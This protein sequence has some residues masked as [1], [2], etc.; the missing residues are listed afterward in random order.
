MYPLLEVRLG[1]IRGNV[2][3]IMRMCRDSGIEP[4]AVIKGFNAIPEIMDILADEDYKYF[5]SSRLPH[6]AAVRE[7][8]YPVKTMAIRITMPSEAADVVEFSD[9]SLNSD[10]GTIRLLDLEARA[11]GKVHK[12]ILMRD[13]GDLREGIFDAE[14]FVEAAISVERDFKNVELAGVGA[15]LCCYGSVLPSEKNMSELVANAREIELAIGRKLEIVS[16]ADSAGLPM[17][18]RG[19]MPRGINQLRIGGGLF[20]RCEIYCLDDGELTDHSDLTMI[21]KAEVIEAGTKPT[22]PIGELYLDAFGNVG[23][24]EDHG[25]RKRVLVAVGAFDVGSCEKLTP[26]DEGAKILGCSSDHMIV[27]VEDSKTEYHAGD[28]LPFS[29]RYQSMLFA[30]E[31]GLIKKEFVE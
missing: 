17:T 21:L 2:R 1:V 5:A 22:Y 9:I 26:L 30:T 4:A 28:I 8:G 31:N 10:I 24:Y 29:M 23:H 16:G 25:T 11:A 7:R 18:L 13:L 15:N 14:K 3:I 12:I 6:L 20:H 19:I 27:D